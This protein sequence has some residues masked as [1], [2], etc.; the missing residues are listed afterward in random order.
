MN[1]D[2]VA[3]QNI[4]EEIN[5]EE[6]EEYKIT[7]VQSRRQQSSV[8]SPPAS[9]KLIPVVVHSPTPSGPI[10]QLTPK[11]YKPPPPLPPVEQPSPI[12]SRAT[13]KGS[14]RVQFATPNPP[15]I[16]PRPTKTQST[17][18][19]PRQSS[20]PPHSAPPNSPPP[21]FFKETSPPLLMSAS[22]PLFRM[23]STSPN[24]D[25][26]TSEYDCQDCPDDTQP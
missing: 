26:E 24:D 18:P 3:G 8:S 25:P 14:R 2:A 7:P 12:L 23:K 6:I 16:P 9:P 4:S 17:S 13:P 15:P 19:S 10:S 21:S 11:T 5:C 1:S 22:N 20:P